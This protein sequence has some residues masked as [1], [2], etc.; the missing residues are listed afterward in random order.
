MLIDR[1]VFDGN[2]ALRGGVS[3][4]KDNEATVRDSLFMNNRSNV[5]VAG[6]PLTGGGAS[7]LWVNASSLSLVNT[8]FFNNNPGGLS[9]ELYGGATASARNVTF[10]DSSSDSDVA[11]YNSVFLRVSCSTSTG[12]RNVQFPQS[13]T[14]PADT[15]RQDPGLA[16]LADNGGPTQ[17]LLPAAN[18]PVLGIGQSCPPTDQRGQPRSATGCDSG[19]VER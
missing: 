14:C 5:N 13:G 3:F 17:T 11:A 6:N 10:V 4:I 19:A 15:V 9:V 12:S 2:T 8:T 1:S 16:A 7:G 18:S